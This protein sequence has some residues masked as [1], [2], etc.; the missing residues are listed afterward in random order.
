MIR[1]YNEMYLS[2]AQQNLALML[3]YAVH[4]LDFSIDDFFSFFIISGISNDFSNGDYRYLSGV[5]GFD[6]DLNWQKMS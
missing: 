6:L 1:A 2:L 4:D 3:D 5:S